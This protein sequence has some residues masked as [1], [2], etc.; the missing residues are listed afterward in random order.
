MLKQGSRKLSRVGKYKSKVMKI[1]VTIM[2]GICSL[3]IGCNSFQLINETSLKAKG[4]KLRPDKRVSYFIYDAKEN[5]TY[6]LSEP[7]PDVV[8][9][10]ATQIASDIGV[11]N[12]S[13]Q[14]D[15]STSQKVDLASKAIELG[16]RTVAVNILR[17]A[18]FRL[19]EMNVNNRNNQ[20][21]DDYKNLFDT[22][23][24]VAKEIA[25]ADKE[26]QE[27]KKIEAEAIKTDSE[28]EKIKMEIRL[29]ELDFSLD[30]ETNYQ[31][32]LKYIINE[33]VNAVNA[34][35]QL[36]KAYPTSFN[37]DEINKELQKLNKD[38]MTKADWIS[39]SRFIAQG[40]LWKVNT[41]LQKEFLEKAKD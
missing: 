32:A 20:L 26:K 14:T 21:H 13:T 34:F 35:E 7:P 39:L 36:Y 29:K 28:V 15:L 37:I 18:L 2:A 33:D 41:D 8:L 40:R 27:A 19:S 3:L 4:L 10:K 16:E 9:E 23:L 24:N 1:N 11:K 22:I 25:L 5:R 12:A 17:D 30:S 6:T 38:G 31:T